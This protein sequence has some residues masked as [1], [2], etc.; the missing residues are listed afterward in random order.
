MTITEEPFRVRLGRA[1][2]AAELGRADLARSVG[3]RPAD[4]TRWLKGTTAPSEHQLMALAVA[5]GGPADR[6]FGELQQGI[7]T[8]EMGSRYVLRS[9]D[10][11]ALLSALGQKQT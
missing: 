11:E 7:T 6:D 3:A 10:P 9:R 4:V 1:M 5:L 2:Q 8:G